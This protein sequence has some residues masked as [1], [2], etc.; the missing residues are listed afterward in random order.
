MDQA[1][2]FL[3]SNSAVWSSCTNGGTTFASIT[4]WI[5]SRVPAVMFEMV[6]QASLRIPFLG[7]AS[8]LS[9]LGSTP[10]LITACVCMSSPVTMFPAVRRAGVCTLA[11]A[12][13]MSSTMR[14]QMPVSRTAWIFSFGPS[15]RYESAQQPSASTSSSV[16]KMSW[17]S[18]G[19]AGETRSHRGCGLPRQRLESVHVALRSIDIFELGFSCSSSGSSAPWF[20]TRSRHSGE[21]PAML[22]SAHTACSRTSSLSESSSCTKMGTAPFEI[23]S[24]VCSDVPDAMLVSAHAAS[25]WR[26]GLSA[27]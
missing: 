21:S 12:C 16:E 7:D 17:A 9:S 10:Q 20:S 24:R 26:A 27:H 15:E 22:P 4:A 25:N 1:A 6:Q 14:G 18:L 2:S 5:C 8:S 3:M 11:C 19:S 13:P 23:T